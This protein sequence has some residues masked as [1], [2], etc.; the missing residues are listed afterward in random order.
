MTNEKNRHS[1]EVAA[2]REQ[3]K[4][5]DRDATE[6]KLQVVELQLE[7]TDL[8]EC[9]ENEAKDIQENLETIELQVQTLKHEKLKLENEIEKVLM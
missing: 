4:T 8:Q 6:L 5:L 7:K 9:L 3:M 2:L 1:V